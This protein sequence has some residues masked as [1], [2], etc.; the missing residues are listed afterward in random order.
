M[1]SLIQT[2]NESFPGGGGGG[3]GWQD[4]LEIAKNAERV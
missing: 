4:E 2:I 3:G 1:F